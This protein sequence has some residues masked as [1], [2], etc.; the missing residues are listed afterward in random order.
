LHTPTTWCPAIPEFGPRSINIHEEGSL[1]K[2]KME[3]TAGN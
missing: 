2:K 1:A 3:G